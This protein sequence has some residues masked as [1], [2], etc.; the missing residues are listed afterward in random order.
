MPNSIFKLFAAPDR[1]KGRLNNMRT[2]WLSEITG[3]WMLP[4]DLC[5]FGG[6]G[7]SHVLPLCQAKLAVMWKATYSTQGTTAFHSQCSSK[8]HLTYSPFNFMPNAWW[9]IT[10]FLHK[11]FADRYEYSHTTVDNLSFIYHTKPDTFLPGFDYII[12]LPPIWCTSS[13]LYMILRVSEWI[14]EVYIAGWPIH[15]P[16]LWHEGY[17]CG[18]WVFAPLFP[19]SFHFASVGQQFWSMHA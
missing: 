9:I 14:L 19:L 16:G 12:L 15:Q 1:D 2:S 6:G 7:V 11:T 10:L 5:S 4:W 17:S 13:Q 8:H 3:F 18:Y